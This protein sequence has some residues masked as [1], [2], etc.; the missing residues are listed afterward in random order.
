MYTLECDVLIIG[1]GPLGATY[2]RQILQPYNE[3][4]TSNGDLPRII[5]LE[6]GAQESK[7]PGDHKKNAVSFQK[8]IDAFV[9]VIHGS[10]HTSS[11]PTQTNRNLTLPPVAWSPRVEQTFNGQNKHQDPYK[12]LDANGVSRTVG[13]M[14]THWTCSTPRQ[15]PSVE[16]PKIYDDKTW[17]ELYTKAEGLIGT[18]ETVLENSIRQRL[19]LETLRNAF[20]DR[21]VK[22]LPLAAKKVEKKNLI[23]W[24][25]AA[26]VLADLAKLNTDILRPVFVILDQHIC[27]RLHVEKVKGKSNGAKASI[28]YAEVVDLAAPGGKDRKII[29][30]KHFIVCGGPILTPQLLY[31]SGFMPEDK[32]NVS[33]PSH[34]RLPHLGY[35]LTEQPMCFSQIVLKDN[36]V[37]ELQTRNWESEEC[38]D[39]RKKHPEDIL[40]IP[41]DDLDPQVSLPFLPSK[42]WHTQIHRDA[43]SY[44]AVPPAIDKRTIVD[45]RY[46]GLMQSQKR[47]RL[48][49]ADDVTDAYG[50]PQPTFDVKL[51]KAD[52]IVSHRMMEDMEA[53]AGSLGGYLPG[54]E[55]QFLAPG[56]A[57]HVCG[58]TVAAKQRSGATETEMKEESCCNESSRIWDTTNLYVGG[59]N[60]VPGPNASNPTLTAMCFAIKGAE[61]IR[62]T[63]GITTVT[64]K[65]NKKKEQR[66]G[67][68]YDKDDA[69]ETSADDNDSERD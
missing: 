50:M 21:K 39:H 56:L 32:I 60:V 40:G 5:M 41:Y 48:W 30:A 10:L 1:S 69:L 29:N 49:F 42:P 64:N 51:S 63:L 57:L 36:L 20:P 35:N 68:S 8:D 25:S 15:D 28:K 38:D 22:P 4:V 37:R 52:R 19:V 18:S 44:G 55:P 47:N 12:N 67:A 34:L 45:L 46:F 17:D 33:V 43:F 58:T 66:C 26:T 16:R 7:I 24:S 11:V 53:V 2:A 65:N 27:K 62:K 9:H 59:L 23:T 6:S 3:S 61:A 13:G 31:K 54:S 14:A